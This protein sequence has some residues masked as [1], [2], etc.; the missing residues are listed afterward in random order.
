M[1]TP[2]NL[3]MLVL[4]YKAERNCC[5]SI[6]FSPYRL[7]Y[8]S[9]VL[10]ALCPPPHTHAVTGTPGI[11]KSFFVEYALARLVALPEPPPYIVWQ[12]HAVPNDVVRI[13]L[14]GS[15]RCTS[16]AYLVSANPATHLPGAPCITCAFVRACRTV[17]H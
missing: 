8:T 7:L 15:C 5:G 17:L 16:R 9:R 1:F 12:D 13:Y 6:N 4:E 3:P 10:L 2:A 14:I 11:G